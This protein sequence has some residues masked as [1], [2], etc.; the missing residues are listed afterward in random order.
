M[1]A[2]RRFMNALA[3]QPPS[4]QPA[5]NEEMMASVHV[6]AWGNEL[7]ARSCV[8]LG[9]GLTSAAADEL[10]GAGLPVSVL[11]DLPMAQAVAAFLSELGGKVDVTPE[12][13]LGVRLL[14]RMV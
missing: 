1:T 10:I 11:C 9:L 12:P 3:R 5:A 13:S 14:A 6:Y 2:Y 8:Q 7:A 4:P